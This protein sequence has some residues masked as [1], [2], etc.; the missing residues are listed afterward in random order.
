MP[1]MLELGTLFRWESQTG[2]RLIATGGGGGGGAA[3]DPEGRSDGAWQG[4]NGGGGGLFLSW[5]EPDPRNLTYADGD[6][7]A[8]LEAVRAYGELTRDLTLD[9]IDAGWPDVPR[10]LWERLLD[11]D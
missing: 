9:E 7:E 1:N 6:A 10:S 8:A 11:D 3:A 4:S 5:E 2:T